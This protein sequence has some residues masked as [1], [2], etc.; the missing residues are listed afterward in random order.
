MPEQA[1]GRIA[2]IEVVPSPTFSNETVFVSLAE[3]CKIPF[4][5][6]FFFFSYSASAFATFIASRTSSSR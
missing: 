2:Y 6:T 5:P 3:N 1:T 4:Y